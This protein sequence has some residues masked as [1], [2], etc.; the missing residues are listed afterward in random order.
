MAETLMRLYER[1]SNQI[2]TLAEQDASNQQRVIAIGCHNAVIQ[3][4]LMQSMIAEGVLGK[5]MQTTCI[6]CFLKES[7]W[8]MALLPFLK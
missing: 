5:K 3:V 6:R 1:V 4:L 7:F 2:L 8:K